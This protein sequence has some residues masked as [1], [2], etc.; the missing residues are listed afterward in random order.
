MEPDPKSRVDVV[1]GVI[2]LWTEEAKQAGRVQTTQFEGLL[3]VGRVIGKSAANGFDLLR[4]EPVPE[5]GFELPAAYHGTSGGGLWR[6]YTKCEDDGSRS[7]VQRRLVG[8]AFWET[9]EERHVICHGQGSIY[10]RLI[11]AIRSKWPE[12]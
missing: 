12:P 5:A 9:P 10:V 4:F 6:L 8:V 7:L 2:D 3:N 11:E 1:S